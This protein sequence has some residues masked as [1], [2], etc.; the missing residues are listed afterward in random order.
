MLIN[1]YHAGAMR[2]LIAAL[3]ALTCVQT[4][5]VAVESSPTY[6]AVA[7]AKIH[8]G[9]VDCVSCNLKGADLTNTC[10]KAHDLHGANFDG[11]NASLMCMSFANF[12]NATFRGTDLSAAN[13]A[14]AKMDG[15]DLTGAKLD[16]TSL[17]GTDLSK[18]MGLT[19]AQIDV[20]CSDEKTRLPPGL[21]IHICQ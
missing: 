7:V 21:K 18:T 6:D 9:I 20:A 19:Q 5:A 8:G 1:S 16:I 15:A 10:V 11:A 12:S 3:I 13:L 4:A 2:I 17:L 14:G